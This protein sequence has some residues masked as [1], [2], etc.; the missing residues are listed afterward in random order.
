MAG[1]ILVPLAA[2]LFVPAWL[3]FDR[4]LGFL[5]HTESWNGLANNLGRFVVKE[6]GVAGPVP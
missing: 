3:A 1:A 2:L 5:E 4:S 6:Y